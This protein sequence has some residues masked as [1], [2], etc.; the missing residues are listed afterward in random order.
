MGNMRTLEAMQSKPITTAAIRRTH[1]KS[2]ICRFKYAHDAYEI[3]QLLSTHPNAKIGS[4][5]EDV[6][7][8]QAVDFERGESIVIEFMKENEYFVAL[9]KEEL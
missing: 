4:E 1:P 6:Y 7:V 2:H 9:G 8:L 3:N 5:Y